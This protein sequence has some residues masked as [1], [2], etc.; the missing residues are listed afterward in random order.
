MHYAFKAALFAAVSL[1][2]LPAWAQNADDELVVTATRV[3]TPITNLPADV[4]E[5]A[6]SHPRYGV[7]IRKDGF[8]RKSREYGVKLTAGATNSIQVKLVPLSAGAIRQ[9]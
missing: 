6:L 7:E 1:T 3:Q 9:Y 2:A 5:I 8:G 4:K